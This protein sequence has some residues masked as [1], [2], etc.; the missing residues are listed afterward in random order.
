[1]MLEDIYT[2]EE[3]ILFSSCNLCPRECRAD[4]TSGNA[5]YCGLDA[6]MI[7]LPFAFIK[8]KNLR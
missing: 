6:G 2:K 1:M 7:S 8:E 3:K 5:G 4:R